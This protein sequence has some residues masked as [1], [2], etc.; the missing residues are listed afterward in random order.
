M[1]KFLNTVEFNKNELRNPRIHNASSAP[2][3]PRDGQI[4][5]NTVVDALFYWAVDHW[6]LLDDA[7][8]AY[9]KAIGDG[10]STTITVTHNLGTTS[11]SVRIYTNTSPTTEVIT[12]VTIVDENTIQ[13]IFG[14]PPDQDEFTVVVFA[15]SASVFSGPAGPAGPSAYEVAV[16]N[17]YTGTEAQWLNSLVS[18]TPG[19]QGPAGPTGET[20]AQG[21]QGIMGPQGAQGI[22]GA[23][24]AR[25]S[26]WYDG[27][28]APS[29]ITGATNGDYYLN[30]VN[31]D[32]YEYNNGWTLVGNIQGP[33]G[34]DGGGGSGTEGV[35]GS[36]WYSG[37]GAPGTITGV[38][39]G[40]HYLNTSNGD[41]YK[42]TTSWGIVGNIR[43]PQGQTGA[44][45]S[46]GTA[47]TISVGS[48]TTGAAGTNATVSN[49][50]SSSAAVLNFTIP[51][52]AT[53]STG[54]A[55]TVAVGS[56]TTGAAGTSASVS[57]SGTSSAAVFNFTI[58]RGDTGAQGSPG[59]GIPTGGTAGQFL[60]KNSSTNYDA[61]WTTTSYMT[62]NTVQ[63][64][65]ANKVFNGDVTITSPARAGAQIMKVSGYGVEIPVE[66]F[67]TGA[68][69]ANYI[70]SNTTSNGANV[71]IGP[72][73]IMLRST[74]SSARYKTE[75][76]DIEETSDLNPEYLLDI[77]V[78][79]F[80]FREEIL[81]ENDQR[82]GQLVPGFIAEEVYAAYP[83]AAQLDEDGNPE[84]WDERYIIPGLLSLIQSLWERVT[85]LENS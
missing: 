64:V 14:N 8:G 55:A 77:P 49:S 76:N 40:D 9:T 1:P 61:S 34:A 11:V 59:Q 15:E 25:G 84:N 12:D 79:Q 83:V 80:K 19:P 38:L 28:T 23:A 46:T 47:A 45:G 31:G 7:E 29:G 18:T 53:G 67:V 82:Y 69:T 39:S 5:Y 22:Q 66:L 27:T 21:I 73:G 58:P 62:L 41:V 48:T 10:T 56:T 78:R 26:K 51:R 50:G 33:A 3:S 37:L 75:I 43:G 63:T 54:S 65:T 71:N 70:Y 2:T 57:N 30:T 4:Y 35:R 44:T 60:V 20:G 42:Y 13:L 85:T 68:I 72:S 74:A 52:G 36:L 32:V 24:G 81:D 6:V 16:D 17:G